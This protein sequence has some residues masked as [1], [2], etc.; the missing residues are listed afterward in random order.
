M[1]RG[2]LDG[3]SS[4]SAYIRG[5]ASWRYVGI[6]CIVYSDNTPNKK[7]RKQTEN[8][9]VS[10]S[11]EKWSNK[12]KKHIHKIRSIENRTH[13]KLLV[14]LDTPNRP[15]SHLLLLPSLY[16]SLLGWSFVLTKVTYGT[17]SPRP[18]PSS[19][20]ELMQRTICSFTLMKYH[21]QKTANGFNRGWV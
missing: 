4:R 20:S 3:I 7:E 16:Y 13:T 15:R 17:H 2:W 11:V 21:V 19:T 10:K 5:W 1:T 9:S 6:V 12:T 8:A 18:R 14:V